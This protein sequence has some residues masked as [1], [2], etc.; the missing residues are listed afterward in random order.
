MFDSLKETLQALNINQEN[1]SGKEVNEGSVIEPSAD[2]LPATDKTGS[3]IND[4]LSRGIE[5]K[6]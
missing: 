5:E 3:Q 1:T 6:Q 4:I 2:M